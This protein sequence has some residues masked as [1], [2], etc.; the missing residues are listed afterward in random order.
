[1]LCHSKIR[2][3]VRE[4]SLLQMWVYSPLPCSEA[5]QPPHCSL[6]EDSSFSLLW[7]ILQQ[8]LK[9]GLESIRRRV[10]TTMVLPLYFPPQQTLKTS[11]RKNKAT[12]IMLGESSTW[13]STPQ[14]VE[15]QRLLKLRSLIDIKSKPQ[16][17]ADPLKVNYGSALF[18]AT[19]QQQLWHIKPQLWPASNEIP[20]LKPHRD[21]SPEKRK[22]ETKSGIQKS[23]PELQHMF[24]LGL[25][26]GI[27]VFVN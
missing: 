18:W 14:Q 24:W 6:F 17:Y 23:R 21:R 15:A 26:S 7:L 1:M 13:K 16:F 22:Y 27:M 20:N 11:E 3:T 2:P 4:W 8:G 25:P 19:N 5:P 12:N 9:F 10:N